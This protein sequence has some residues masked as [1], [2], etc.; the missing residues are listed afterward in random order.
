MSSNG[1]CYEGKG[2]EWED[3]GAGPWVS[4]HPSLGSGD[5]ENQ[6]AKDLNVDRN[7]PHKCQRKCLPGGQNSMC[8]GPGR[9]QV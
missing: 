2:R 6:R 8:R 5:K 1:R 7:W 4:R 3:G 9:W